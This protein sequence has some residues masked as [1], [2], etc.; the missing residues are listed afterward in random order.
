MKLG[1]CYYPE[2]WPEHTWPED[3]RCMKALGI[4]VVRI[5][6]F[7]WSKLEPDNRNQFQFEWLH[8]AIDTLWAEGLEVVLGTPTATPPK[9]LVD[10]IPS[11]LA[12]DEQGRQRGF[13]SRR[14]YC[15]SSL[16]YR[17]ECTRIVTKLAQQFGEHP[18]VTTWQTDNEYGCHS[19][20][21]SYSNDALKSFR[22]WCSQRY[23]TIDQL[24]TAWGNVFWSMEYRHFD[25]IDLPCGAV[26]ELNP[27]HRLA[28][29]KFS[30]D[31]VASFNKQQTD[32][33]RSY[34]PGRDIL[35]NYMGNFTEF[36]HYTTAADLDIASW[37]N[38]PLGFLDRDLADPIDQ[39]KWFRTG[40]PDSS[41][42]HHDLYR[43][44]GRGRMWVMEQ[45][46]GPVNWAPHNPAPLQGMVRLWAL[47]AFAHDA[48]VMS[49]FRWRQLPFAQEQ[50]HTGLLLPDSTE[51]TAC[52]E[53]RQLVSDLETIGHDH[54][55]LC[56]VAI[57]FDYTGD[58]ICRIQPQGQNFD[59]L[60]WV[61][62]I[63][64]ALRQNG[65]NID[66]V[67][68]DSD[69][70]SYKLVVLANSISIEDDLLKRLKKFTGHTIIG[71]RCG[72]KTAEYSIPD[73][74]PPGSLQQIIPI[75]VTR[76]ESLPDF[77]VT[78]SQ[79]LSHTAN[80]WRERIQ[81]AIEPADHFDDGW[82][83]YYRHNKVH[84]LNSCL[85]TESLKDF[86]QG[87]LKEADISTIDCTEG[88]RL[89]HY[90]SLTFAFNYGPSPQTL[91]YSSEYLLGQANL[92]AGDVAV[93]NN[94]D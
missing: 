68:A 48:E 59:P 4:S 22:L 76:V 41:T 15:F 61:M 46:P 28:F 21:V 54:H 39:Q 71:P 94:P 32:I 17:A 26:T 1:V 73:S 16:A 24:N 11:I 74:L 43:G 42:F 3:A 37:D 35:H 60:Q 63:Y 81:S 72:S 78:T 93:W 56:D 36:D 91:R 38:Y 82:G 13:G 58:Q 55:R 6:E 89:S 75:R 62:Q 64:T 65:V 49:W 10:E 12:I 77:A 2:H 83:Y 45:Q 69:L 47:E 20:I 31:Q 27:A 14:H 70:S 30:S 53:I 50:M 85:D 23:S 79:R 18:A 87:R 8:N 66:V 86:M 57:V 88:L 34:S 92:A 29:W 19:T 25:E 5:G 67:P 51:D 52:D 9:W 40:H 80:R 33:L 7:A 90:G 44:V 84:Y